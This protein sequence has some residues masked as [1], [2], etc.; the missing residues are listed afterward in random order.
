MNN[1]NVFASVVN[2]KHPFMKALLLFSGA[3]IAGVG[4][5][6]TTSLYDRFDVLYSIAEEKPSPKFKWTQASPAG[7]GSYQEGWTTGKWPM[8]FVPVSGPNNELWMIGQN[9]AWSS[10][11]GI[12][13][14]AHPKKDWGERIY[15]TRISFQNTLLAYGGV[16]VG[17]GFEN[18]I[19]RSRDGKNWEQ[20]KTKTAWQPRRGHAMV[21][22]HNQLWLFGGTTTLSEDDKDQS[23]LNDI[24]TSA[25][26]IT[27]KKVKDNAPWQPR[28]HPQAA[29][30]KDQ[31][32]LMGG[33]NHADVWRSADGENW[34]LVSSE[35]PWKGREDFGLKVF[36]NILFVFGGRGDSPARD[37][38]DVW[39]SLDGAQWQ[40]QTE[41]AP[42][43]EQTANSS[44]VF[45][46]KLWLYNGKHKGHPRPGDIWTM[47]ADHH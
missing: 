23:M 34:T 3:L 22:F 30:F 42:W 15:M 1:V 38:N 17:G 8:G 45:K 21:E 35:A 18:D 47:E 14:D 10:A 6:V 11:D 2:L 41:H 33:V 27:W 31:L 26:G 28:K 40:L 43:E 5:L 36:E 32:W 29:V 12:H 37:L 25:D 46:N 13:W 16:S 4:S 9:K 24:W 44:I 19:W 7:T 20:L 39:Y